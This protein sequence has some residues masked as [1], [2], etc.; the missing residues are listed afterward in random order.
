MKKFTQVNKSSVMVAKWSRNGREMV[1]IKPLLIMLMILT[2][3]VGNAWGATTYCNYNFTKNEETTSIHNGEVI[4]RA[5]INESYYGLGKLTFK[6]SMSRTV[7][8]D[9]RS[10]DLT[11]DIYG[12]ARFGVFVLIL[13]FIVF[14]NDSATP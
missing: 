8:L 4:Y 10:K 2:I 9:N 6:I 3:G 14:I 1:S 11:Y 5:T 7:Y 12:F 13:F